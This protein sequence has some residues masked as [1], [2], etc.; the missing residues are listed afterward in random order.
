VDASQ[1]I[2]A[3]YRYDPFGRSLYASG[4][5]AGAN[6]YRFSS[7][8]FQVNGSLYYYGYRWYAP[9]WQRWLNRDPMGEMGGVN[10]Y[11]AMGNSPVNLTDPLGL[12]LGVSEWDPTDYSEYAGIEVPCSKCILR[13]YD[14]AGFNS[15]SDCANS[16]FGE[17]T[18]LDLGLAAGTSIL[19]IIYEKAVVSGSS[20]PIGAAFAFGA[21]G[22]WLVFYDVCNQ[23]IQWEE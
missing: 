5:K 11:A 21:L 17:L 12:L 3:E 6:V 20:G 14:V 16:Y 8:A 4:T 19:A 2:S 10:L 1:V 15:P 23:C 7:K 22:Q 13:H 9:D 18:G